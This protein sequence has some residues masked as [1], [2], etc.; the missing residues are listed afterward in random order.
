M[1]LPL[2]SE[3]STKRRLKC[4]K[5]FQPDKKFVA[6]VHLIENAGFRG[7]SRKCAIRYKLLFLLPLSS[8][9]TAF[10]TAFSTSLVERAGSG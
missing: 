8:I 5:D 2:L 3:F 10:S 4:G 7:L 9:F 1:F 6:P